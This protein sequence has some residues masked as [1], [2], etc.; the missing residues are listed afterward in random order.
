MSSFH[1]L[2]EFDIESIMQQDKDD[3]TPEDSALQDEVFEDDIQSEVEDEY[4][5]NISS[6]EETQSVNQV[7]ERKSKQDNSFIST[8][9]TR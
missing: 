5:D 3:Y 8:Y 4:V 6:V 1:Q 9:I 7:K 2:N